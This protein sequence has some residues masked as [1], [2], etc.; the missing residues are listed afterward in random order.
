MIIDRNPFGLRPP[1]PVPPQAKAPAPPRDEI[2]LTGITSIGKRR[3][4][5]MSLAGP[6][7]T[8]HYFSMAVGERNGDLEV[9][10]IDPGAKVVRVRNAGVEI[11]M[12]FAA[13]GVKPPSAANSDRFR[14]IGFLVSNPVAEG[15]LK[16]LKRTEIQKNPKEFETGGEGRYV[17]ISV[18]LSKTLKALKTLAFREGENYINPRTGPVGIVCRRLAFGRSA[19]TASD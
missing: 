8:P 5:F 12:T 2:L 4:Y 6:G 7:H 15:G 16:A 1:P 19:W 9:L 3:A 11:G 14:P 13:N 17:K 18:T 10:S